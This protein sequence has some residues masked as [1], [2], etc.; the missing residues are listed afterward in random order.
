MKKI[1]TVYGSDN[2]Q[3]CIMLKIWLEKNGIK[4]AM[5]DVNQNDVKIEFQTYNAQGIPLII[6]KDLETRTEQKIVG[7][8]EERL[9]NAIIK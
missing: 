1:I 6:I 7:F 5:K 3:F 4:Y 2:C 9:K 8:N